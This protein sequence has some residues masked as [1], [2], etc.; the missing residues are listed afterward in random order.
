MF[1]CLILFLILKGLFF[2]ESKAQLIEI[3]SLHR[4][5][6][7]SKL[8]GFNYTKILNQI[9]KVLTESNPDSALIISRQVQKLIV[10][11]GYSKLKGQFY[12]VRATSFSYLAQYD[13]SLF[14]SFKA[15]E[16]AGIDQDTITL[17]DA[18]NNLGIDFLYQ[19]EDSMALTYFKKVEKLSKKIEDSLRWAHALNNIGMIHGYAEKTDQELEYYQKAGA[20]FNLIGEKEG[21]GNVLL[22]T[23]TAHTALGNHNQAEYFYKQALKLFEGIEYQSAIAQAHINLAENYF[24]QS[25][26]TQALDEAFLTLNIVDKYNFDQDKIYVYELLN[27][28]YQK[29]QNYKLALKFQ[30]KASDLKEQIFNAE[31]SLQI[32]ELNTKYELEVKEA[33]I[34]RLTLENQLNEVQIAETRWQMAFILVGV[35]VLVSIAFFLV[36]LKGKKTQ[37]EKLEQSLRFE[38]LQKRFMELLNGPVNIDLDIE[39]KEFN[40]KLYNALTE[41]E[42]DVLKNSMQGKTNQEIADALFVSLS[43][44][45]F[46]M[47]NIYNKLGVSNKKEALEYVVKSS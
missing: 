36:W 12:I 45:K 2:A 8:E 22:N 18:Y 33:E 19:E 1:R 42:F 10:E 11:K 7:K 43:T 25:K 21:Y 29:K 28:I 24:D 26:L 13:S 3:D 15:L 46:H 40:A 41:R 27:K 9:S 17:I 35:I 16:Q 38:A 31:K 39:L 23:G 44:I 20:L 6:N 4:E 14:Y 34:E 5:L 30:A 47:G 32:N 37:A